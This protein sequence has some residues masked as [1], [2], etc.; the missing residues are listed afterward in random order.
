VGARGDGTLFAP[1][2]RVAGLVQKMAGARW[3]A[4][5]APHV[6]PAMDRA[7]S[8]VTGGRASFSGLAVPTMVLTTTG[9]RTGQARPTPLATLPEAGGSYLVVGSNFGRERH[10]AWSA[11]LLA[12]PEATVTF[13]GATTPVRAELLDGDARAQAWRQLLVAWPTYAQYAERV[14]RDLRVFRLS[15]IA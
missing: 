13:R 2:G 8:K 15:P 6:V 9:A 12:H 11:N 14:Q 7:L 3:F 5:V 10:P 1:D 4:R